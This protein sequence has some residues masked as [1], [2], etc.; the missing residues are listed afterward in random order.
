MNLQFTNIEFRGMMYNPSKV[1][2]G[3]SVFKIFPGM[4]K[5]S[6]FKKSPGP[7][8]SNDLTML[9]IF[10]M[11][12]KSTPYRGKYT[13]VL[14]R[15]IEIAHDVGFVLDN[16]GN[17]ED[18][19]E[20]MMK[21]NNDVVNRKIVEFV[22][23]HRSFKYTYL[24]TIEASYY[25]VMQEVMSGETK[26]IPDLRSIQE[27]LEDTM[28]E[29]LTEDNN[30]YIKDAILRYVEEERLQLR[31]EDIALKLANNEQPVT[32]KEIR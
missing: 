24:V 18:P 6:I 29:I 8:L 5:Y 27:E 13:D 15:K 4:K 17:F 11:Y 12:D 2:E 28:A 1:P 25:N 20:D 22:R 7:E 10:C 3:E 32:Y 26:R 19:V 9:Y 30:P 16:K 21:G 23:I 31:P 14:K